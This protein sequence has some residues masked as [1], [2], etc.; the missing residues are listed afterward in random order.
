MSE[1]TLVESKEWTKW[2]GLLVKVSATVCL[3]LALLFFSYLF[4]GDT[5]DGVHMDLSPRPN[6]SA[7]GEVVA[8]APTSL[9]TASEQV[10]V[11]WALTERSTVVTI[12]GTELAVNGG[13]SHVTVVR[14]TTTGLPW[15]DRVVNFI[16]DT[17]CAWSMDGEPIGLTVTEKDSRDQRNG[18]VCVDEGPVGEL[19]VSSDSFY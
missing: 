5:G 6:I 2:T 8:I 4:L 3:L 16:V 18:Y 7:S 14:K 19:R 17:R 10:A 9:L 13:F 12:L 1:R 15:F 11:E